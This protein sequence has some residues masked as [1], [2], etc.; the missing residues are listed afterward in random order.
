MWIKPRTPTWLGQKN[1]GLHIDL[2]TSA[3]G[4]RLQLLK[5]FENSNFWKSVVQPQ[6]KLYLGE[7]ENRAGIM[8]LCQVTEKRQTN[9][10]NTAQ[11][12]NENMPVINQFIYHIEQFVGVESADTATTGLV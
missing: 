5:T 11:S 7:F 9:H 3:L 12:S 10:E 6:T 1:Y 2:N 8:L 4:I